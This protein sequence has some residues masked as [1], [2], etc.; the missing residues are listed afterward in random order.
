[1]SN[2]K[3]SQDAK[4]DWEKISSQTGQ[5]LD[6]KNNQDAVFYPFHQARDLVEKEAG[7]EAKV[8]LV[9]TILFLVISNPQCFLFLKSALFKL[10]NIGSTGEVTSTGIIVSGIL[11]SLYIG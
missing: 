10:R 1:M 7:N 4:K 11:F 6:G 5:A 3:L 8:A 9:A 2:N